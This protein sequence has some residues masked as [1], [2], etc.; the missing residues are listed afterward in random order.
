[1]KFCLL[2]EKDGVEIDQVPG[3]KQNEAKEYGM[4]QLKSSDPGPGKDREST[5]WVA[6]PRSKNGVAPGKG[7]VMIQSFLQGTQSAADQ[8]GRE[9]SSERVGDTPCWDI[10]TIL[11]REPDVG[12]CCGEGKKVMWRLKKRSKSGLEQPNFPTWSN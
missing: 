2:R 3:N 7:A 4:G 11:L 12:L 5:S 1:M 9:G 8:Q 6:D 10:F